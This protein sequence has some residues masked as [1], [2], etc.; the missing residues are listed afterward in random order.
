MID[1]DGR[2]VWVHSA[3][4]GSCIGRFSRF[5]VDVH[6]TAD[7]M[8]AG[9]PQCLEC[10]HDL[11]PRESWRAFKRAMLLHHEAVV[12]DRYM[13]GF[14]RE[15]MPSLYT[16]YGKEVL[17]QFGWDL[18]EGKPRRSYPG[19]V[20]AALGC[21][22]SWYKRKIRR[23]GLPVPDDCKEIVKSLLTEGAGWDSCKETT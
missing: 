11:P 12:S 15:D 22:E 18:Y 6:N 1:T 4:D 23:E 20:T 9:A 5:G 19:W 3:K 10:S 13:P 21:W 17:D 16:A 14:V 8:I 2:T 7:A